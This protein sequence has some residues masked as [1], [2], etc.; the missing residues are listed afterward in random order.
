MFSKFFPDSEQKK[1][2]SDVFKSK[3][4]VIGYGAGL[5]LREEVFPKGM[6]I[7]VH[8][9]YHEQ[10]SYVAS[11]SMICSLDDGSEMTLKAGECAYFG[12]YEKHGLVFLEDTAVIDAFTPIRLDHLEQKVFYAQD[13]DKE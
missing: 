8:S 1:G 13:T 9:H 12:P 4:R 5:M 10:I 2:S 6:V 7:P 3:S 11:G